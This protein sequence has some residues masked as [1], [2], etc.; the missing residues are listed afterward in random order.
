M[1]TTIANIRPRAEGIGLIGG[2]V[3]HHV[4]CIPDTVGES[5]DC[6]RQGEEITR[7]RI[8]DEHRREISMLRHISGV[9]GED[10]PTHHLDDHPHLEELDT[11]LLHQDIGEKGTLHLHQD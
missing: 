10:K 9:D 7:H 4:I 8:G 6:L 1:T 11:D 5:Q 3:V 2:V